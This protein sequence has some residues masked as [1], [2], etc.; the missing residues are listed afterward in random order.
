[1]NFI[2]KELEER[3]ADGVDFVPIWFDSEIFPPIIL[4]MTK[5]EVKNAEGYPKTN[6]LYWKVENGKKFYCDGQYPFLRE[7]P[8]YDFKEID[9][10]MKGI[11]NY[12]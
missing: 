4:T 11:K 5:E 12:D 7:V 6:S 9:F 3:N 2:L 8:T 1:M 10:N